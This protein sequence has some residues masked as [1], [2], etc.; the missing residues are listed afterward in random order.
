[1]ICQNFEGT[2]YDNAETWTGG[3]GVNADYTTTV[4][5]GSQS[6]QMSAGALIAPTIVASGTVYGHFMFR[7]S[8]ATPAGTRTI[9]RLEN[10]VPAE[11]AEIHIRTTGYI[12]G[13]HGSV[14]GT[15]A[16]NQLADNTTYHFWFHYSKGTGLNGVLE[17]WQGTTA[18]RASATKIVNVTTGTS[19]GDVVYLYM[20]GNTTESM[21]FDQIILDETAFLTV[22][23]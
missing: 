19:T 17:I 12:R 21:V 22:P 18:D 3:T 10:S 2:G 20:Y 7:C 15:D 8:D 6:L 16:A 23:Q 9:V 4:L 14:Y 13:E 11:L 1:M 5:R